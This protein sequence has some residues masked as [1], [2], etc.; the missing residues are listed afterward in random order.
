[1]YLSPSGIGYII[2]CLICLLFF[3]RLYQSWQKTKTPEIEYFM[4][5]F[6][7]LAVSFLFYGLPVII[8]NANTLIV[9]IGII[10]GNFFVAL[11]LAYLIK[12]CLSLKN[13]GISAKTAF[14]IMII[15]GII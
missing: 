14:Y 3:L 13:F 4:K 12:L 9:G 8:F 7:W 6:L 10:I 5:T 2:D 11:S 15:W 1:M